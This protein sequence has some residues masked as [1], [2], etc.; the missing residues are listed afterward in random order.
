MVNLL[1]SER[2]RQ[3]CIYSAG[4]GIPFLCW[5]HLSVMALEGLISGAE[6]TLY[7][8]QPYAGASP[9]LFQWLPHLCSFFC[10]ARYP[11]TK[12]IHVCVR[13]CT[14]TGGGEFPE[15]WPPSGHGRW[16]LPRLTSSQAKY[17]SPAEVAIEQRW[18]RCKISDTS[19][20]FWMC[21]SRGG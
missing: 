8:G 16:P 7:L 19:S 4:S 15:L 20:W 3:G 17:T 11:D 1:Y 9:L 12:D 14:R 2:L 13:A 5:L 6:G 18:H 10:L 21:N